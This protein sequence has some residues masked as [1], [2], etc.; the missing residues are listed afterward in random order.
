VTEFTKSDIFL[1]FIKIA[2][3]DEAD[4]G[5]FGIGPLEIRCIYVKLGSRMTDCPCSFSNHPEKAREKV[6]W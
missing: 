2:G 5:K 3:I 6:K 4:A 1:V